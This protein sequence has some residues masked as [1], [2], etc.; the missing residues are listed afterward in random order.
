MA[1]FQPESLAYFQ[2]YFTPGKSKK[3][4]RNKKNGANQKLALFFLCSPP[5]NI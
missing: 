3:K 4:R 1:L 2:S 5:V